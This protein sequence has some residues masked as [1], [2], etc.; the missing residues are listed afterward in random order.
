MFLPRNA[1]ESILVGFAIWCISFL[2][3]S[4]SWNV[5]F[6]N[7]DPRFATFS[8]QVSDPFYRNP[9]E[10]FM[11]FRILIPSIAALLHFNRW[12]ALALIYA[13]S[14]LS[15]AALFHLLRKEIVACDAL[16]FC[17][18]MSLTPFVQGSSIYLGTPDAAGWLMVAYA[19]LKPRPIFWGMAS[20][21]IQMNDERG[22]LALPLALA[23][24]AYPARHNLGQAYRSSRGLIWALIVGFAA[25]Q[26]LRNSIATGLIGGRPIDRKIYPD[27]AIVSVSYLFLGLVVSY[28]ALW[29]FAVYVIARTLNDPSERKAYWF[30]FGVLGCGLFVFLIC[31]YV[32]DYWRSL[33]SL[34]PLFILLLLQAKNK[35]LSP[36]GLRRFI[37]SIAAITLVLPQFAQMGDHL[38][39]IRPLP[40]A[41]YELVKG[42]SILSMM[43]I[44]SDRDL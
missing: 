5:V 23:V 27:P 30:W 24:V 9:E 15:L 41:L 14:A 43:G 38:A 28:K 31:S 3:S 12:E 18:T 37:L 29:P 25:G 1:A 22:L 32:I 8:Q 2:I 35:Y 21:L 42:K 20:F 4:P 16:S 11:G 17:L 44:R 6:S 40:M 39:W 36:S 13:C 33:A 7:L 19:I 26:L 10:A 34:F